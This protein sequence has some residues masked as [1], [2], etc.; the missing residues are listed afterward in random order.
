V[1]I[2]DTLYINKKERI[3]MKFD[4][5]NITQKFNFWNEA[6]LPDEIKKIIGITYRVMR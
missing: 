4:K 5:T 6:L 3:N 1:E 2:G